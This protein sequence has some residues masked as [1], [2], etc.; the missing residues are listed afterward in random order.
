[1]DKYFCNFAQ[2]PAP[3]RF[4][5]VSVVRLRF[6][7]RAPALLIIATTLSKHSVISNFGHHNLSRPLWSKAD[8]CSALDYVLFV[9]I[10]DIPPFTR[11]PR[12]RD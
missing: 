7:I 9:P 2:S 4:A 10:V 5:L 3:V 8:M 11:S 1:M 6:M 12:R